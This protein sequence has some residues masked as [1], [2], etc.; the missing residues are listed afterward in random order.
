MPEAPQFGLNANDVRRLHE[1]KAAVAELLRRTA[2]AL[3]GP[4]GRNF[5]MVKITSADRVEGYYE[6]KVTFW[7]RETEYTELDATVKIHAE[8]TPEEGSY[9][10][11]FQT[12]PTADGDAIFVIPNGSGSGFFPALVS[13]RRRSENFYSFTERRFLVDGGEQ[14]RSPG[15]GGSCG[16]WIGVERTQLGSV[17]AVE[18]QTITLHGATSGTWYLQGE[19]LSHSADN[20]DVQAALN[21]AFGPGVASAAG[22]ASP[23]TVTWAEEGAQSELSV[24]D[25]ELGPHSSHPLYE[26]DDQIVAYPSYQ[27]VRVGYQANPRFSLTK[28]QTGNEVDEPTI[29]ELWLEDYD[30]SEYTLTVDDEV[31]P[32][33]DIRTDI[34]AADL[35]T[36]I[37][38]DLAV[39]VSGAGTEAD[40]FV[41]EVTEDND[42]HDLTADTSDLIDKTDYRFRAG[43][44]KCFPGVT[45]FDKFNEENI[46]ALT[47]SECLKV[48][49][50]APCEI[51]EGETLIISG[52]TLS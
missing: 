10:L 46:L 11:A 38:A 31:D 34:N 23:F 36:A 4:G 21:A 52:G 32:I 3:G 9:H 30:L 14:L 15:R 43:F 19:A 2:P 5:Q 27:W 24:N 50:A 41:I 29:W 35:A 17:S 47:D 18:I 40:P 44:S 8:F 20:T 33:E 16:A 22:V 1:M 48:L 6:G 12:G 25:T 51:P 7:N 39:T 26:I 45:G 49:A 28:V 42:D 13:D 37:G